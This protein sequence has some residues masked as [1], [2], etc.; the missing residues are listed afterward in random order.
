MNAVMVVTG[1]SITKSRMTVVGSDNGISL[2]SLTFIIFS[3]C[4][5]STCPAKQ[6]HF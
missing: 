1:I 4:V 3:S 6:I 2:E 5:S